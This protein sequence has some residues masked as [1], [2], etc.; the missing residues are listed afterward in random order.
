[1]NGILTWENRGLSPVVLKPLTPLIGIVL[2]IALT[3]GSA[4]EAAAANCISAAT[5]N[6]TVITWTNCTG[7]PVVAP[8]TP[9]EGFTI[10]LLCFQ[11][12][13]DEGGTT[14]TIFRIESQA[15][16]GAVATVGFIERS[17]SVSIEN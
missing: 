17:V 6:W 4:R 8:P 15:F 14:R 9:I 3:L 7:N 10:R 13:Y 5:G 1:M 12:T 2:F 11:N 16:V